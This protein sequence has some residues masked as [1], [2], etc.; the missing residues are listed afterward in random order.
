MKVVFT[1]T[2]PGVGQPDEVREVS[3]GYA[4]NYLLPRKLA[5]AA[6]AQVLAGVT[7]R[8]SRS[9]HEQGKQ[10]A[11]AR[12]FLSQLQGKVVVIKAKAAPSGTLY[13]AITAENLAEAI[14]NASKVPVAPDQL[15]LLEHLKAVGDHHV[16]VRLPGGLLAQLTIRVQAA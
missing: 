7:A 10:V 2:V 8:A 9:Q 5:V 6:T 15:V 1:K 16:S 4:L 3:D 13:A 14:Q 11:Q 12:G